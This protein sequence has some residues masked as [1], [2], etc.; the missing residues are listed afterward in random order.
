MTIRA[1]KEPRLDVKITA[2]EYQSDAV[3]A[4]RD[5]EYAAVFHEQGLG[6][7]KIAIDVLL[8]WLESKAVDSVMIVTKLGLIDNWKREIREHTYIEPRLLG[9]DKAANFRAFN[10]P[11]RVYLMHYE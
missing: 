10:S 9:Q 6:K 4:V 11:A 1:R 2:F 7:T 5:L 3:K 8:W